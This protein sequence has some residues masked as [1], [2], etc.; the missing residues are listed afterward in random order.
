MVVSTGEWPIV[1]RLGLAVAAARTTDGT[2]AAAIAVIHTAAAVLVA[3][4]QAV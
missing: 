3:R 1:V 2:I 4:P